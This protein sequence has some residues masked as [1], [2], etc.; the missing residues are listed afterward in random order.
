[1]LEPVPQ[2]CKHVSWCDCIVSLRSVKASL[3]VWAKFSKSNRLQIVDVVKPTIL[4]SCTSSPRTMQPITE[5]PVRAMARHTDKPIIFALS[6]PVPEL[7]AAQAYHWTD[8]RGMY[9]NFEGAQEEVTTPEGQI[10][11][12]SKVQSVYVFPGIA[13]GT[14]VT[15][16]AILMIPFARSPLSQLAATCSCRLFGQHVL[17]AR[18]SSVQCGICVRSLCFVSGP[19][20]APVKSYCRR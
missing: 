17:H 16:C 5:A 9:A 20:S 19:S 15:R 10:L 13:L 11:T 4:I 7:S 3:P 2:W 12:P 8:G 1:M 14:C 18:R 6:S